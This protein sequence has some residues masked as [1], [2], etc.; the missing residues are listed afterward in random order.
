L[1]CFFLLSLLFYEHDEEVVKLKTYYEKH[2]QL[3]EDIHKWEVL[4]RKM[5]EHE[6]KANDPNR[7]NNRGGRLLQEEKKATTTG[8]LTPSFP[9]VKLTLSLSPIS[10]LSQRTCNLFH[11]YRKY[12]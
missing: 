3:F 8:S 5:L 9:V 7:F 1:P 12:S 10:S 4:Y 2:C 6:K 11:P